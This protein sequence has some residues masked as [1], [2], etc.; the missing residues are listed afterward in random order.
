MCN[1]NN[2][3]I[4]SIIVIEKKDFFLFEEILSELDVIV[5]EMENGD[6]LLE[7][8][9]EKFEWGVVLLCLG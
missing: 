7:V 1:L 9:L 8:V 2:Y 4:L 5:L 6:L 3:C